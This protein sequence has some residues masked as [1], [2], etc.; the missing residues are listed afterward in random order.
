MKM[1]AKTK[2]SMFEYFPDAKSFDWVQFFHLE[3]I[4]GLGTDCKEEICASIYPV[5]T[6][7]Y[8]KII[9]YYA[10]NA[11]RTAEEL[12]A[13]QSFADQVNHLPF[14]PGQTI[15]GLGDSITDDLE[16]WLEI[17]RHVLDIQ[18]GMN[19]VKVVNAGVCGDTTTHAVCRFN[20]I[21]LQNPDWIICFIGT[22]DARRNRLSPNQTT[23]SL[24][25]TERNLTMLRH[26]GLTQTKAKWIWISPP[27]VIENK[28]AEA[29]GT[30]SF[31]AI[32]LNSDL[33]HVAKIIRKQPEQVVDLEQVF[34]APPNPNMFL[35]DGLHPSLFG[36]K[37]ILKALVDTLTS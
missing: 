2:A 32:Y 30:Q 13:S 3:K 20:N 16:S 23:V 9:D 35:F 18:W 33:Q 6:E 22:N 29:W 28:A 8:R 14:R 31:Q 11:H 5:D 26:Y 24:E 21:T 1:K 19:S 4:W 25:E 37:L 36:Q 12:L 34:G 15:A 17:L 10:G 7:Q 27:P